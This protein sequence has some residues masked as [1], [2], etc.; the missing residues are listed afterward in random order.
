MISIIIP[1]PI[2]WDFIICPSF[3]KTHKYILMLCNKAFNGLKT[4]IMYCFGFSVFF[5]NI[6]IKID[7]N[8]YHVL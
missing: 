8:I 5:L 1:S 3:I 6:E 7:E 2:D 4:I